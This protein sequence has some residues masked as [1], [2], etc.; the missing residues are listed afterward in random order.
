M[1][2]WSIDWPTTNNRHVR[3]CWSNAWETLSNNRGFIDQN[4]KLAHAAV[5]YA[6][7]SNSA[8]CVRVAITPGSWIRKTTTA[9]WVMCARR[10]N[11]DNGEAVLREGGQRGDKWNNLPD[12]APAVA[13]A[14]ATRRASWWRHFD[15]VYCRRR[16]RY[17]DDRRV[18][19][20][21]FRPHHFRPRMRR[22]AKWR[23]SGRSRRTSTSILITTWAPPSDRNPHFCYQQRRKT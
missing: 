20:S 9:Q 2:D 1:I 17:D 23:R 12:H 3:K 14:R 5:T 13:R 16:P 11:T 22:C 7:L 19:P 6:K 15:A 10:R 8:R 4:R 21:S 18:F